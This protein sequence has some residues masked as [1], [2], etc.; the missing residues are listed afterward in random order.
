MGTLSPTIKKRLETQGYVETGESDFAR[1]APWLRFSTGVC[2]II[3]A[4]GTVLASPVLLWGLYPFAA[5]G[6]I[7]LRHPF[8][9]I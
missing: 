5:L 4:I 8:D 9:Y 1:V 6:D 7:F 2:S 3:A